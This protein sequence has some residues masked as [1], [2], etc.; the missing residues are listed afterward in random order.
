MTSNTSVQTLPYPDGTDPVGLGDDTLQALAE[1]LDAIMPR[2]GRSGPHAV[3]AVDTSYSVLINFPDPFPVGVVPVVHVTAEV[4]APTAIVTVSGVT[5]TGF[6][7]NYR[8]VSG[9][10]NVSVNWTAQVTT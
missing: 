9:S 10:V 2:C 6:T 8:R 7:L 3:G 5:N 1:R 4:A